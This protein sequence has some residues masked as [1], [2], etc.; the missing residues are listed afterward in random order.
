MTT[1][2]VTVGANPTRGGGR[3]FKW[4][5]VWTGVNGKYLTDG[6]AKFN[7]FSATIIDQHFYTPP[8][9][10]PITLG[11]VPPTPW[12]ANDDV[13]LENELLTQVKG[14][15]FNLAVANAQSHLTFKMLHETMGTLFS[16]F[17]ALKHG[18][19]ARAARRLGVRK[20]TTK[21]HAT[22][23]SGRFLELQYG[24]KPLIQDVHDGMQAYAAL[25]NRVRKVT[26]RAR[27]NTPWDSHEFTASS[28]LQKGPGRQRVYGQI[29]YEASEDLS[30]PRQLGLLDPASVAWELLP[31]SF[32]ADWFIPIGTYLENL[33]QIPNLKGRFVK[34]KTRRF[35]EH[36]HGIKLGANT[37]YVGCWW[38]ITY[39]QIDRTASTGLKAT[40]PVFKKLGQLYSPQHFWNGFA[41][42]SQAVVG[43]ISR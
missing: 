27:H 26:V 10:Y 21:L 29:I 5:R 7:N 17:V 32:V 36:A 34:T 12:T 23:V 42:F 35:E 22:D 30:T 3:Q 40:S 41:L 2:N 16:V 13:R 6:R 15:S 31:Y 19:F 9:K 43:A 11:S 25:N 1:G 24:W 20:T 8:L 14:H 33:N 38:D 4:T 28:P 39:V 18:N 37:D